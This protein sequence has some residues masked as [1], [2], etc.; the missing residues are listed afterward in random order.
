MQRI[1]SLPRT[2]EVSPERL[3]QLS[4][5]NVLA[6][7]FEQ[8]FRLLSDQANGIHSYLETETGFFS[9]KVGGGKTGL[10]M[11]IASHFHRKYPQAKCLLLIPASVYA[12]FW[13]EDLPWARKH[14]AITVPWYGLGK[15]TQKKRL[16]LA[17]CGR[18]GAYVLPYSC[19]ST[20]DTIEVL[21]CIDASLVI[22]DEAQNLR[23]K[24]AKAKRW[25]SFVRKHSPAGVAMSGT[26]TGK[27]LME[28]H[29]LIRWC[30]QG[31]SPVPSTKVDAVKWANMIDSGAEEPSD[32]ELAEIAPLLRWANTTHDTKGIREAFKTRLLTAPGFHTSGDKE[33]GVSLEISN[34]PAPGATPAYLEMVK[35]VQERWQHPSGDVIS[36]GIE[37]HSC[38]RELSAGFYYERY[39]DED[40]PLVGQAKERWE[41]GQEYYKEL[42]DFFGQTIYPREGL[43]TPM[44]VGK[45]HSDH[46]RIQS[47]PDL[48]DLWS[49]WRALDRPD[50]PDRLS[51][52]VRVDDYKIKAA[53]RWARALKGGGILW[54]IHKAVGVWL[55]EELRKAKVPCRKKGSGDEWLRGDGSNAYV[56]VASIDAHGTGKN[57]QDFEH[58]YIVQWPRSATQC[59]QL[60]GRTHRTGQQA[61]RL[62]INTNLTSDWD[63][64]Q[65]SCTIQ[66]TVYVAETMGGRRKLLIADWNPLPTQYP[67]EFLRARGWTL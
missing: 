44:A 43:D 65:M 3:E 19:L 58:Q 27:S 47:A 30:L 62:V 34:K 21:R 8:G 50:L 29:S 9:I 14:L 67:P 24:S 52:P 32:E 7:A 4:K 63:H 59:E 46:G 33:L 18:P 48:Y 10:C 23:G 56:C 51:R 13:L 1:I 2:G 40:H 26:L 37:L 22:A 12:Q 20:E 17:K 60:I 28:Y 64:E 36:Y 41:L 53:V 42:R 11:L 66:D 57:L 15:S 55:M 25:W 16:T 49:E 5:E 38:L 35:K 45:Y 31:N 6:P 61:D 54:V 39:W